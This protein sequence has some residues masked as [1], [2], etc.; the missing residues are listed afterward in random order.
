VLDLG[1]APGSWLMYAA[2]RT[3]PSGKV[4]GVDLT[5]VSLSLPSHVRT[6]VGDASDMESLM[7]EIGDGYDV[8]LGDM[9]PKTTGN[10]STDSARSYYLCESALIIARR[11]LKTGGG[12]VCKIFQGEDFEAFIGRVKSVFFTHKI[13]K[14]QSS[15][16]ASKEI[17]VIGL[18]KR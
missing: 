6:V 5:P 12:F 9:A 1:C 16:K 11:V 13:F 14:P 18:N 17:F 10:S 2:E 7:E 3:G 15:R 4:V 8:V